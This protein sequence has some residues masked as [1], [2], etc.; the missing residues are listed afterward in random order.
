MQMFQKVSNFEVFG[1]ITDMTRVYLPL[2]NQENSLGSI[3]LFSE[4]L[5]WPRGKKITHTQKIMPHNRHSASNESLSGA[6]VIFHI[7]WALS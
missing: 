6:L 4:E 7:V 3:D 5:S 1:L 2:F